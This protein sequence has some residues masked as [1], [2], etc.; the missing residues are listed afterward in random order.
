MDPLCIKPDTICPNGPPDEQA[1]Q[2]FIKQWQLFHPNLLRQVVWLQAA[3]LH[4]SIAVS[5][6][7][8]PQIL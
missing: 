5:S 1:S 6:L 2:S 7:Q 8:L 4:I 3:L